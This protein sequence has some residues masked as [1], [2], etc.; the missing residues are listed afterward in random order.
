MAA[1]QS[2]LGPFVASEAL[3]PPGMGSEPGACHWSCRGPHPAVQRRLRSHGQPWGQVAED[4]GEVQGRLAAVWQEQHAR[5]HFDLHGGVE[6]TA[7]GSSLD[8]GVHTT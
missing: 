1:L 4:P 6:A 2:A 7:Q 5:R 3:R 8:G